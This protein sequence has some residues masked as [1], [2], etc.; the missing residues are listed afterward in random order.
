MVLLDDVIFPPSEDVVIEEEDFNL[1]VIFCSG[2]RKKNLAS[3]EGGSKCD[4]TEEEIEKKKQ[5][6]YFENGIEGSVE[7]CGVVLERMTSKASDPKTFGIIQSF[8]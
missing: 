2:K 1:K 3:Y 8:L 4:V 7:A 5:N 6:V